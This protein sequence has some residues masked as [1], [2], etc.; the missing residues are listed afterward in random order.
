V[1]VIDFLLPESL[2]NNPFGMSRRL[3]D[4]SLPVFASGMAEGVAKN[5]RKMSIAMI[6]HLPAREFLEIVQRMFQSFAVEILIEH[7]GVEV[8]GHKYICIDPQCFVPDA[9]I[10]AVGDDFA[11]GFLDKNRKPFHDRECHK[12]TTDAFKDSVM[13]HG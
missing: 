13:F 11:G 12:I 7:N 9:E 5:R 1:D 8:V 6:R 3:P 4:A 2:G 10:Q